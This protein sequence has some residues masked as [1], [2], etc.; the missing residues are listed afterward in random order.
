MVGENLGITKT[1]KKASKEKGFD[2]KCTEKLY[3]A[4]QA[5]RR[6]FRKVNL[7]KWIAQF[8]KLRDDDEVKKA[9]IKEILNWYVQNIGKDGVLEAYSAASFREKFDA[10]AGAM[11]RDRK[12]NKNVPDDFPMKTWMEGDIEITEVDYGQ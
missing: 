9:D 4:L 5:K 6:V 2:R 8:K 10:I 1:K 12:E 11:Y 3:R 7:Y